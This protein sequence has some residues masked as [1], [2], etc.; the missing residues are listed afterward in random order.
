[1]L[2]MQC[3]CFQVDVLRKCCLKF[4]KLFLEIGQIDP[5][6]ESITI[7]SC[8][9][10]YYRL[11]H[12]PLNR[13]AIVPPGGYRK[14]ENQSNIALKWLKWMAHNTGQRIL[15]KLNGG[16]QKIGKWRVDGLWG[17]TCFEFYG[18]YW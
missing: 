9:N 15:H 4:R 12:L 11:H 1:M 7:A 16:E 8:C 10:K 18:C 13:I 3:T 6:V 14:R 2:Y 17:T 5:F